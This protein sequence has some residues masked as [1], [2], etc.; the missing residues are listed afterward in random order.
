MEMVVFF[1]GGISIYAL[2][3]WVHVRKL[4]KGVKIWSPNKG[5]RFVIGIGRDQPFFPLSPE[6]RAQLK[7]ELAAPGEIVSD[8]ELD[9]FLRVYACS[10]FWLV[11]GELGVFAGVIAL[12]AWRHAVT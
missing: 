10:F 3:M 5:A 8:E 4:K 7:L 6:R 12:T 1:V 11:V 2:V 9:F